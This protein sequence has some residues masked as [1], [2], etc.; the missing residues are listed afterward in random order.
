MN[1]DQAPAW[2]PSHVVP[3]FTLSYPT[4]PPAQPD[5]FPN[6]NYYGTGPLDF[7]VIITAIALMAVLRDATRI[8]VME[9]FA[10][11]KLARDLRLSK[12]KKT[13][14]ANRN[15]DAKANGAANGH[16]NGNGH[17]PHANGSA[18]STKE[19]KKM[20]RS[21]IRFAEQGWSVVYYTGM[22]PFGLY[23]HRQ[24][25]THALNPINVWPGY[26]HIP[27]AGPIKFYYMVQ[28]AFYLHQILIINA[29]ARRKDHW[30]MMTHHVITVVLMIG[31]YF[32]NYTRVGCL[33]MVLMDWCDIIF[34]LAKMFR[35]LGMSTIC[36]ATFVL[37]L[38]SWLITRHALFLLTIKATW[39]AWYTVPRI[40]D[41]SRGHFMTKEIYFGFFA[42]L[43]VLQI[44][45][46]V[47][48]WMICRVAYRVVTGQGAQD[49]RSDDEG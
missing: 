19:A 16:A 18:I 24:L 26:P 30:Q 40:W 36:D 22:I 4:S 44:I 1:T 37:F 39:E 29:E 48:F 11:W 6:S 38:V 7:C 17:A 43:V 31:S 15:G 45:Q 28:T 49:T 14:L 9:P 46:L 5:S 10:R 21:V 32:Y 42:M 13:A 47:W 34:P 3:F 27:L 2:L 35:Y 12:Q 8:Y 25:P 23:I 33:I 41:P 20:K